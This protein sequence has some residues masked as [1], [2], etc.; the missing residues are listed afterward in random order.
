MIA[1]L[2]FSE[3]SQL[4]LRRIAPVR[5]LPN[6]ML[7]DSVALACFSSHFYSSEESSCGD[8][9]CFTSC[10]ELS[11]K[12]LRTTLPRRSREGCTAH[13]HAYRSV[14]G[15]TWPRHRTR[16]NSDHSPSHL[17]LLTATVASQR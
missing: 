6:L 7:I 5:W 11:N 3:A 16:T 15:K 8:A 12:H 13:R 14:V 17:S 9:L 1:S 2:H 10:S 4:M